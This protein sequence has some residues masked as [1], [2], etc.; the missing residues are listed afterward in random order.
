MIGLWRSRRGHRRD[1]RRR[2]GDQRVH[3]HCGAGATAT[4][5]FSTKCDDPGASRVEY[6]ASGSY[7]ASGLL[8]LIAGEI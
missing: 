7:R 6:F 4:R 8:S 2:G 5:A 1:V 3:D